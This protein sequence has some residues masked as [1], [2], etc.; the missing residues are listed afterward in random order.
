MFSRRSF[1]ASVIAASSLR[2]VTDASGVAPPRGVEITP[3]SQAEE[4][5]C[6]LP[7]GLYLVG[8]DLP[9]L[10]VESG[11]HIIVRDTHARVQARHTLHPKRL[12]L[13][14]YLD[15]EMLVYLKYYGELMWVEVL[16]HSLLRLVP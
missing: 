4:L 1:L 6:P 9:E 11:D 5:T 12:A 10:D 2:L 3:S 15:H 8:D 13:H 7:P 14:R 16:D